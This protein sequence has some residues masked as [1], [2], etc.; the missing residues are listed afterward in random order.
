MNGNLNNKAMAEFRP[1]TS[2]NQLANLAVWIIFVPY[3]QLKNGRTPFDPDH[4]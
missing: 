4:K 1:N 2:K 3:K